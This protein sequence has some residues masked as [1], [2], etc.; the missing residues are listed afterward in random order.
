MNQKTRRRGLRLGDV[1]MVTDGEYKDATG[2]VCSI[3]RGE[4]SKLYLASLIS[5]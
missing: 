1:I 2:I 4:G 3:K 5:E